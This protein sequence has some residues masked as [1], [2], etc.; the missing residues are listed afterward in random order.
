MDEK[1][2]MEIYSTPGAACR[3]DTFSSRM[4]SRDME[5][6]RVSPSRSA[7]TQMRLPTSPC[8]SAASSSS[9]RP[10]TSVPSIAMSR[11][12]TWM[13]AAAA[14]ECRTTRCTVSPRSVRPTAMPMPA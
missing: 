13:P 4:V 6:S 8:K 9:P 1:A 11:S 5:K 12:P 7:V 10:V 14:G 2:L 3:A